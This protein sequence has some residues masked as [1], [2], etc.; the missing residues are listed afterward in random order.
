[1][2]AGFLLFFFVIRSTPEKTLEA[3]CNA[4]KNRDYRTAYSQLSSRLQN[5]QS[6]SEFVIENS[7]SLCTYSSVIESGSVATSNMTTI[8]SSG[9]AS[10]SFITLIEDSTSTWKI[11]MLPSTPEKTLY[12]FCNDL[13]KEDYQGAYNQLASIVQSQVSEQ[14]FANTNRKSNATVKGITKCSVSNVVESGSTATGTI[15]FTLGN[16]Q[17]GPAVYILVIENGVWKIER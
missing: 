13:K 2:V 12:A 5:S 16:G 8:T 17:S 7:G 1:V 14:D 9:G 6:E 3:F 10:N 11:N 15:N 4:L